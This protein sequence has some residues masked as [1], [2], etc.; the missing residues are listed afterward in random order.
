MKK[1]VAGFLLGLIIGAWI[2]LGVARILSDA[3]VYHFGPEPMMFFSRP[4]PQFPPGPTKP[5]RA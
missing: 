5:G 1:F 3:T 4:K 2:V